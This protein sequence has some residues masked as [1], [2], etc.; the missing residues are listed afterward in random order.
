MYA[1]AVLVQLI[2]EL[3]FASMPWQFSHHV[4]NEWQKMYKNHDQSLERMFLHHGRVIGDVI[5]EAR[6]FRGEFQN[7]NDTDLIISCELEIA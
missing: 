3:A 6:H 2:F 4:N 1:S 5:L 7:E